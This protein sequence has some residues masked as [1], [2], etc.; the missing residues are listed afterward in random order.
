M[1][2]LPLMDEHGKKLPAATA[3][4]TLYVAFKTTCPTCAFAWP[5]LERVRQA[6]E[7]GLRVIA[8]SQDPPEP[9][10]EFQE[11]H[12]AHIELAY[13]PSPWPLSE[14]LGLTTVPTFFR[15]GADGTIEETVEGWDRE[16][17]RGFA[18]RGAALAKREST[19]IIRPGEQVPA[20]KPG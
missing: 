12:G 9:T 18:R 7:G 5:Y 2:P 6:S 3:P 8:I 10:R 16:R 20:I 15:V 1:P 13:D 4:E 11:R 19:D 14:Q 17:M